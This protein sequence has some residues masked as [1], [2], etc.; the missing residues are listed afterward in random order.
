LQCHRQT[1]AVRQADRLPRVQ[2]A[3]HR[4]FPEIFSLARPLADHRVAAH[5]IRAGGR[6]PDEP[7]IIAGENSVVNLA[8]G[9]VEFQNDHARDAGQIDAGNE[10]VAVGLPARGLEAQAQVAG[11]APV[12]LQGGAGVGRAGLV[13][14]DFGNGAAP[15][16][17]GS[18]ARDWVGTI[19]VTT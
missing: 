14:A 16:S 19:I 10:G 18:K 6:L 4:K 13:Q 8:V 5:E 12:L 2:K 17:A 1:R 11:P 9:R 7:D 3:C 15:A